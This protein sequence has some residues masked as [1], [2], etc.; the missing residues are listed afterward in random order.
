MA[1]KLTRTPTSRWRRIDKKKARLPVAA[2]ARNCPLGQLLN[3]FWFEVTAG[4]FGETLE[5]RASEAKKLALRAE[6]RR[7][8]FGLR[9]PVK[10]ETHIV[11]LCA[12][13]HRIAIAGSVPAA[14]RRGHLQQR[15]GVQFPSDSKPSVVLPCSLQGMVDFY[16]PPWF[17]LCV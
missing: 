17:H 13:E 12:G 5:V 7:L 14:S 9:E 4:R 1:A 3:E 11:E 2:R 8:D 10:T 16:I 6:T 15:R